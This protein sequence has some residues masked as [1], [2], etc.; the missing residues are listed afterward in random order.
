MEESVFFNPQIGGVDDKICLKPI[1]I[2]FGSCLLAFMF[3]LYIRWYVYERNYRK[4]FFRDMNSIVILL[5]KQA[6][7]TPKTPKAPKKKAKKTVKKDN[8]YP[9]NFK[10]S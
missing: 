3:L 7:P 9:Y 2:F 8:I 10:I 6:R 1:M 4:E 5:Q